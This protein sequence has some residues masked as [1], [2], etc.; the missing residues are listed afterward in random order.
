MATARPEDTNAAIALSSLLDQRRPG[1]PC[2]SYSR[3]WGTSQGAWPR[4]SKWSLT[5]L[6]DVIPYSIDAASACAIWHAPAGRAQAALDQPSCRGL[7]DEEGDMGAINTKPRR[8]G[9]L[10]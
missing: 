8:R 1:Q 9:V 7:F 4:S 2:F 10:I 3:G 6:H 5:D